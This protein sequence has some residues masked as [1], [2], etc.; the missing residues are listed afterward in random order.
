MDFFGIGPLEVLFILLIALI[1]FGPG[2]LPEIGRVMGRTMRTLKKASFDLTAQVAKEIEEKEKES[3]A[4]Q[5]R[6][7]STQTEQS[8]APP[9]SKVEPQRKNERR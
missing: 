2:K 5:T 9:P 6:K 8:A 3:T 4:G 7:S 1:I